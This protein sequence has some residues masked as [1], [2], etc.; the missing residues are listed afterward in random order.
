MA[1]TVKLAD[2]AKAAKVSQG[3]VSNVF[4]RPDMVSPEMRERVMAAADSL[5]YRGPDPRGRLLRAGR[6]NAIGVVTSDYLRNFFENGYTRRFLAGI[7]EECERHGAGLSLVSAQ[8]D[9]IADWNIRTAVVDGFILNCVVEGSRLV[10]LAARRGLPFVAVEFPPESGFNVVAADDDQGGRLAASHLIGLGHRRIGILSLEFDDSDKT[11]I[12]SEERAAQARYSPTRKRLHGYRETFAGAGLD[13]RSIPIYETFNDRETVEAGVDAVLEAVPGL[14]AFLCMSDVIAIAA[15]HHLQAR[16]LRVP[17]DV[18][19]I[20]FDD[21]DDAASL[22]PPLTTIRQD[23]E[24]KGRVAMRKI[25]GASEGE[26]VSSVILPVDL[27]V[28]RSTGP[29]REP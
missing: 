11:G 16:G 20:G 4:N 8:N 29:A 6:V 3:T 21:I 15:V 9:E 12:V 26:P 1:K 27:V 13:P 5:G 7:A 28:R 25:L 22:D 10:D 17:E 14:T 19:V 18:S 23:I 2:V 24:E